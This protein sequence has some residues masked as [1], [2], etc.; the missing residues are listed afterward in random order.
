M[1]T[2]G[3]VQY[4]STLNLDFVPALC[5][6]VHEEVLAANTLLCRRGD[7]VQDSLPGRLRSLMLQKTSW[8]KNVPDVTDGMRVG[9]LAFVSPNERRRATVAA[10]DLTKLM[11]FPAADSTA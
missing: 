11:A 10:R 3:P 9:E 7:A 5:L 8:A 4:L 2:F 1:H 6:I